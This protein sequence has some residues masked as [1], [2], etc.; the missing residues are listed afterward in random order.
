VVPEKGLKTVVVW[1][2]VWWLRFLLVSSVCVVVVGG[3]MG[4]MTVHD[5]PLPSQP[6]DLS[7]VPLPSDEPPLP[8]CPPLPAD[9]LVRPLTAYFFYIGDF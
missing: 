7:Q 4:S 1:C 5:I 2:V 6:I 9:D 3:L 8:P